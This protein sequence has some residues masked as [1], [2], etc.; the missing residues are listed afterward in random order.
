MRLY[1]RQVRIHDDK[2]QTGLVRE[3]EMAVDRLL[4]RVPLYG[5][6]FF[7]D[8]ELYGLAEAKSYMLRFLEDKNIRT[9]PAAEVEFHK[10]CDRMIVT[11]K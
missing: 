8:F 7:K 9:D 11:V 6:Q 1:L 5:I 3:I 4:E 10:V 2:R